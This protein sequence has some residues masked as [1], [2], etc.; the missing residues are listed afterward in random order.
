M[1]ERAIV[2]GGGIAGK[3]VAKALSDTFHEVIILEADKEYHEITP[4]KRVPQSNHPHV[5]LKS[6]EIAIEKL[7]PD[8]FRQ[9]IDKGSI[10]SNFTKDLKWHHFGHWKK[11]FSGDMILVQQSRPMLEFHLQ[12]RINQVSNII[13]KYETMADQL[14]IDREQNKVCGVKIRSLITGKEEEL[15]ASLVVDASGFASKSIEWLK[16]NGIYVK[17]ESVGIQ[18]F[19][20]TRL[21]RLK[22]KELNWRNLLISPSFPV[23]PFGAF[24]QTLEDNRFSVTF[25][26]YSNENPPKTK[27]EFE[28]YAQ[29]LPVPDVVDFL[30]EA[31]PISDIKIHRIPYQSRRRY[32]QARDIPE[33]FLVVG[34]AHCRFDPLFGHGISVAAMQAVELQHDLRGMTSLDKG[35]TQRFHKKISKIIATPWDM[36][37]TEAFRHPHIEGKRT[38]VLKFKQWYT[39]K[40]YMAS[41]FEP[42]IYSRLVKVMNLV[43]SPLHLFH[44][45]VWFA[46]FTGKQN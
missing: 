46:F 25:S 30:R 5:L 27:E 28:S 33:G 21:F 19:Y 3:L 7:F 11:P 16:A 24:I 45:K 9:L 6:G 35:F 39:K 42:E 4:R 38:I 2:I 26:G 43:R 15:H 10:I 13:T 44:P 40:V 22:E 37:T 31:E 23:N 29:K 34:D 41:A 12:E 36:A 1:L 8:L 18:L 32:D 17:E 20:S 14:L